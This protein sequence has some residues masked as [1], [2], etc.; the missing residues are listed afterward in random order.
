MSSYVIV[1]VTTGSKQEA[2]KIAQ[3]LLSEHLIACAN[4]VGPVSSHFFW[5]GKIDAAEEYLLVMKSRSTLFEELCKR[6]KALH[7]YEVP[8]V[9]AVPIVDVA[10]GYADWLHSVLRH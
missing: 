10:K 5:L 3:D 4:I 6:V 2:E 7:S 9:I 1:Y 8:E